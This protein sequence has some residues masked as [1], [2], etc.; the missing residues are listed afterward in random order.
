MK[1][2]RI[3]NICGLNSVSEL[4]EALQ[5]SRPTATLALKGKGSPKVRAKMKALCASHQRQVAKSY[6]KLA[7]VAYAT[8]VA[9]EAKDEN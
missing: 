5:V 2:D 6:E 9:L 1:K 3:K 4:A 8:A 7:R